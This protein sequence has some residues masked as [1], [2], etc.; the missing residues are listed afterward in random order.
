MSHWELGEDAAFRVTGFPFELVEVLRTT[1]GASRLQRL[2][3]LD[4]LADEYREHLLTRAF[5]SA[6]SRA[7]RPDQRRW[8]SCARRDVARGRR[9]ADADGFADAELA[10]ALSSWA[11]ASAKVSAAESAIRAAWAADIA[12]ISDALQSTCDDARLMDALQRMSGAFVAQLERYRH[13]PSG[14]HSRATERRLALYLQRLATKNE[15]N[16]FFGPV[17]RARVDAGRGERLRLEGSVG[18][19]A[20]EV[21]ATVRLAQGLGDVV[22]RNEVG[23]LHVPVRPHPM[24][25][26]G[27][28]SDADEEAGLRSGGRPAK[29]GRD[30]RCDRSR[31]GEIPC[32]RR[33]SSRGGT[34]PP[35]TGGRSCRRGPSH[36]HRG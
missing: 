13:D 25:V 24:A 34:C 19:G 28:V 31:P 35:G 14:R 7:R 4:R 29:R 18:S 15:T 16:S 21:F 1:G 8:L 2:S 30:R 11:Q 12:V 6:V 26:A 20:P 10:D 36:G 23:R 33:Q 5:P 32:R 17:G 9:P 27:E 3:E 22:A